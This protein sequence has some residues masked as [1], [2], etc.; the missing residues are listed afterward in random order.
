MRDKILLPEGQVRL[1]GLERLRK[2][3]MEVRVFA[4]KF[5]TR[6]ER[7]GCQGADV[8]DIFNLGLDEP[9][10]HWEMELV[11]SLDFWNF[12]RYLQLHK[13][14]KVIHHHQTPPAG[15]VPSP[16]PSSSQAQDPSLIPTL[17]RWSRR[18]A[19]KSPQVVP[20][21]ALEEAVPEPLYKMAT[22]PESFHKMAATPEPPVIMDVTPQ[23]SAITDALLYSR[24]M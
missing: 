22:S 16:P 2:K 23:S 14:G 15:A 13:E 21:S 11:K 3:G 5:W 18:R 1:Q 17:K 20:E 4:Q 10:L 12:S 9:L 7:L 8:K 6:A 19:A 24:S